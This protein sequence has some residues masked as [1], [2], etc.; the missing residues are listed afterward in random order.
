MI[1]A[2]RN[3]PVTT[4][5][6]DRPERRNAVD[7]AT[8][9]ELR[10]AIDQAR[11]EGTRV[12]VLCGAGGTFCAGADLTGVEGQGFAAALTGVLAGLTELPAVTLAAVQGAALGAGTQLAIACD[13]RVAAPD[14]FFGIPASRL[15]LM[16]DAWTVQRLALLVGGSVARAVLLAAE[17]LTADHAQTLGLVHRIGGVDDA[18]AW[19]DRLAALAPLSVAGHKL[20]LERLSPAAPADADV[21]AAFQRVWTSEDAQEGPAAFLA[22]RPPAFKGR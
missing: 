21:E 8:L 4:V 9:D 6:L 20:A 22:K 2:S 12:L 7:L 1:H 15:G 11:A 19:A 16:V 18:L 5:T 10:A 3:G 13:L 17:H 14:A